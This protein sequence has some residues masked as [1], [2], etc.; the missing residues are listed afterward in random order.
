MS[1]RSDITV[2]EGVQ[3]DIEKVQ[4]QFHAIVRLCDALAMFVLAMM[5]IL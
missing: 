3:A 1:G 2:E 5:S 4:A